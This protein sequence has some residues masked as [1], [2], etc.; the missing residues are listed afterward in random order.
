MK[1]KKKMLIIIA[2]ISIFLT[3]CDTA[4]NTNSKQE[5]VC[6]KGCAE[7]TTEY[8]LDCGLFVDPDTWCKE[9]KYDVCKRCIE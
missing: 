8:R 9:R 4:E 7:Y 5:L 2:M 3:G 1:N 6:D